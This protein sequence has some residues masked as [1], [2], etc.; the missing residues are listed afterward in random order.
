MYS[1]YL[2]YPLELDIRCRLLLVDATTLHE[3]K[4]EYQLIDG[5]TATPLNRLLR[6]LVRTLSYSNNCE[7][8]LHP[9]AVYLHE[10]IGHLTLTTNNANNKPLKRK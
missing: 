10:L 5:L 9:K 8:L 1:I 7:H 6:S 4:V 3:R 2:K